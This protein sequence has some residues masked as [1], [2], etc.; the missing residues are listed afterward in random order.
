MKKSMFWGMTVLV[1][2]V[3]L[4]VLSGCLRNSEPE[5]EDTTRQSGGNKETSEK[6]EAKAGTLNFV[7]L[8]NSP[9][10][11]SMERLCARYSKENPEI[12]FEQEVLKA[13]AR[14]TVLKTRIA[15]GNIPHLFMSVESG[16][17]MAQWKDGAVDLSDETWWDEI[18]PAAYPLV[19]MDDKKIAFPFTANVWGLLYNK[20]VFQKAGITELP[21]TLAGLKDVAAT[22]KSQ[23]ITPFGEGFKDSWVTYQLFRMP[24]GHDL[25]DFTDILARF[26]EYNAG[27]AKVSEDTWLPKL[28]DLMQVIK[29]NTQQNPFNTDFTMQIQMLANGEVGMITQG[30]WAEP[31]A[32]Q[33]NPDCNIGI[34]LMPFSEDPKDAK[35]FTQYVARTIFVG[36][37]TDNIQGAKNFIEWMAT[38]KWVKDWYNKDL[39]NIAP[40]KGVAP[41]GKTVQILE[42]AA[43]LYANPANAA[44]WGAYIAPA[45]LFGLFPSIQEE[46][47]LGKKTKQE[48]IDAVSTAWYNYSQQ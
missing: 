27:E 30:D 47:F 43:K 22:L 37:N 25:G 17:S 45:E 33:V 3:V 29:D 26:E 9:Y 46:F 36:R 32:R 11:E 23:G 5:K 31:P 12:D 19:T 2:T 38:S 13:D 14:Y 4:T 20:D 40:I 21:K 10:Y 8:M 35:I 24:F 44:P 6:E 41:E 15:S 18:L 28:L 16:P 7:H 1:I 39:Q 42:D 48:M 34:M